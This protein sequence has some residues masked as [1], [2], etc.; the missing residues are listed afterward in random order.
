M[1]TL[2]KVSQAAA[3]QSR[4]CNVLESCVRKQSHNQD[5]RGLGAHERSH[6]SAPGLPNPNSEKLDSLTEGH[7]SSPFPVHAHGEQT[8][9]SLINWPMLA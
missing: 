7:L 2:E 4:I 1:E 6:Q 5:V 3:F 9:L 8:T